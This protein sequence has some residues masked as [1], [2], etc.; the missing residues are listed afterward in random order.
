M[1]VYKSKNHFSISLETTRNDYKGPDLGGGG[2]ALF[3]CH[4][5]NQSA[6]SK[7][8]MKWVE[9]SSWSKVEVAADL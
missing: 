6:F 3:V 7:E 4:H 1:H 8:Y 5:F 2:G 9:P